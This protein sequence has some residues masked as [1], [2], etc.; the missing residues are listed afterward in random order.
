MGLRP[1]AVSVAFVAGLAA[2][3]AGAV[4][5]LDSTWAEEG[6]SAQNPSGGFG[7]HIALA[8]QKQF[9]ATISFTSDGDTFGECT[10]T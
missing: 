3:P 8:N 4:T 1:G 10:G 9:D 6:G 2:M 5:I 7:A